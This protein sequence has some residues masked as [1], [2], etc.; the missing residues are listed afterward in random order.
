MIAAY[1]M[2]T[3][4]SWSSRYVH[5]DV[6]PHADTSLRPRAL[7]GMLRNS[8]GKLATTL[9]GTIMAF[10]SA[11]KIGI[12]MRGILI[13]ATLSVAGFDASIT[14]ELASAAMQRGIS[15]GFTI[16]TSPS[17]EL[18][19]PVILAVDTGL[20]TNSYDNR[21]TSVHSGYAAIY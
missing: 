14:P 19:V 12:I 4:T 5:H 1:L 9:T 13:A 18:I 3:Q 11:Q 7:C 8:S 15:K 10:R 20:R 2:Y 16:V 17:R 6:L 21:L